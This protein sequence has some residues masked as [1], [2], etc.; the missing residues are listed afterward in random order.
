[1]K[2][3]FPINLKKKSLYNL[4]I[5]TSG[6]AHLPDLS[7]VLIDARIPALELIRSPDGEEEVPYITFAIR[8]K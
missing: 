1:M 4:P 8:L 2:R 6:S 5:K 3:L 7:L